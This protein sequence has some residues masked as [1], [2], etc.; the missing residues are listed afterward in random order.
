MNGFLVIDK[1]AGIT[2]ARVVGQVKRML[3]KNTKIGHTGTLD[4]NVT[5]ILPLAIGK[6][7][8]TIGF[9]D[10]ETKTYRAT[11]LLGTSTDTEDVW[12]TVLDEKD[13]PEL[14]ASAVEEAVLS[15]VG[16]QE[17]IPPMYS[18]LKKDGK[19][20][21]DLARQG[22]VVERAPRKITIHCIED[23]VYEHPYVS[24]TAVCSRGTYIRTLCV[25]MAKKLNTLGTMSSLIRLSS[26]PFTMEHACKLEDLEPQS[27]ES[28]LIP[29]DIIFEGFD[30]IEVDR[31][32]A[33][34]LLNGVKV[35]L[36]RFA[37]K[38]VEPG[39]TIKVMYDNE[40]IGIATAKD[41]TIAMTQLFSMNES[42]KNDCGGV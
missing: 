14:S 32:H 25:D 31:L 36:M 33:K 38:K 34:H 17:Q 12:G 2:S 41:G 6:A 16:E 9:M 11:F 27:I 24:Y 37:K 28:R 15:F 1:P 18:A 35:E 19:R 4:P 20:L 26:G 40:L 13:C 39:T 21:Y 7:T 5:G 22:M 30:V 10:N 3:P 29:L 42:L 8:K 23:I